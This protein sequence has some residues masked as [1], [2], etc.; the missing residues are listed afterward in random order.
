MQISNTS[1]TNFNGIEVIGTKYMTRKPRNVIVALDKLASDYVTPL[2]KNLEAKKGA[3]IFAKVNPDG[4]V[5]LSLVR[6]FKE[7]AGKT[8]E[9]I[10]IEH[11]LSN[12]ANR[13]IKTT[14]D[15]NSTLGA[16]NKKIKTFLKSCQTFLDNSNEVKKN[17]PAPSNPDNL[18]RPA[19]MGSDIERMYF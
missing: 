1:H 10:K 15:S 12:G 17:F 3:D 18:I 16:I 19:R 2:L 6:V 7:Y 5:D 13:N 14:I 9:P 4:K 8:T 11:V